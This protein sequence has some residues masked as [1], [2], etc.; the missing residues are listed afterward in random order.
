MNYKERI[1]DILKIKPIIK[2]VKI[3]CN[4]GCNLSCPYCK[5][6]NDQTEID[7]N[8]FKSIINRLTKQ[9]ISE[10]SIHNLSEPLV[11]SDFQKAI[12]YIRYSM[13]DVFIF[14]TTNAVNINEEN[15]KFILDNID[16]IKI[17][18]NYYDSETAIQATGK[19][20]YSL[21]KSN[22][23]E[24]RKRKQQ[25]SSK[26]EIAGS[27]VIPMP[28]KLNADKYTDVIELFESHVFTPILSQGG[29]YADGIKGDP[30]FLDFEEFEVAKP[31]PCYKPFS[32]PVIDMNGDVSYCNF[33]I[34]STKI[35][36]IF[37]DSL[38]EIMMNN[39]I[40]NHHLIQDLKALKNTP[41]GK[42]LGLI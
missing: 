21:V 39:K 7:L 4:L 32:C 26:C 40:L 36:N 18:M 17:S 25:F 30:I 41:C 9:N 20:I 3:N 37:K 11:Y 8:M 38:I 33:D 28:Y 35:G 15:I 42:C 24:L 23:H 1:D 13:P 14:I 12:S 5:N 27:S 31:I 6:T 34:K 29:D 19:D 16:C 2:N 10:I 22:I